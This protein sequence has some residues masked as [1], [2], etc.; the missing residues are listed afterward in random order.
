MHSPDSELNC[1]GLLVQAKTDGS[2]IPLYYDE[3]TLPTMCYKVAK[4]RIEPNSSQ[5][6]IIDHTIDYNRY[7]FNSLITANKLFFRKHNRCC[8]SSR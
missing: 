8:P 2:G 5:R 7:I 3:R 4:M 1:G 6:R